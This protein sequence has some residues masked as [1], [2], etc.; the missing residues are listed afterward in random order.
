MPTPRGSDRS[1][2]SE[3]GDPKGRKEENKNHPMGWS[4]LSTMMLQTLTEIPF[5]SF[6]LLFIGLKDYE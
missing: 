3:I 2:C 6:L 5:S 1:R 4:H